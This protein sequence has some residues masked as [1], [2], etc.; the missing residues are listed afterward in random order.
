MAA[1]G[2]PSV[3]DVVVGAEQ[4]DPFPAQTETLDD[5]VDLVGL[6]E[7]SEIGL[8][9]DDDVDVDVGMDEVAVEGFLGVALVAH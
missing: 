4:F 9:G 5:L 2:E 1:D 7:R 3:A 6:G 8:L